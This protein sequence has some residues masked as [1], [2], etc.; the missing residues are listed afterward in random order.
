MEKPTKDPVDT[1]M[2][3]ANGH[4]EGDT[5]VIDV[6]GFN[7]Y[8]WFDRAGNFASEQLHVVERYTPIDATHLNYE[9]TMDD[10]Q[11]FTRPWKISMPLY[12]IV[13]KDFRLYDY[14]CVE[15][16]E[17]ALYGRFTTHPRGTK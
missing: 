4:W 2:G 6:R 16:A 10:P 3:W 1:W 9:A 12:R 8:S 5:L 7:G 17:E 14:R 13:D 11:T 15:L